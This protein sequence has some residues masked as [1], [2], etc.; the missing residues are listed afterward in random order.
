MF[1]AQ[2]GNSPGQGPATSNMGARLSA[3]YPKLV[4]EPL[5]IDVTAFLIYIFILFNSF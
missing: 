3:V 4:R 2:C 5:T 1:S